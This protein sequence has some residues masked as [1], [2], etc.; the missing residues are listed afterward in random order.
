MQT[1]LKGMRSKGDNIAEIAMYSNLVTE[2]EH[3]DHLVSVLQWSF[4]TQKQ[5]SRSQLELQHVNNTLI[6]LKL[7]YHG[8]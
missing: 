3:T 6:T 2:F 1:S 5:Y 8:L 7:A 4:K